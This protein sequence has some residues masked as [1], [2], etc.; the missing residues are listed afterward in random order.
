[1]KMKKIQVMLMILIIT[2]NVLAG[3][4]GAA[5]Q[6]QKEPEVQEQTESEAQ[7]QPQTET[8]DQAEAEPQPQTE[9]ET[10]ADQADQADHAGQTIRTN[11]QLA[12]LSAHGRNLTGLM[13]AEKAETPSELSGEEVEKLDRAMRAYIPPA[14]SLLIN[15]AESFYYYEQMDK[16]EQAIYDALLMCATDPVSKDNIVLASVSVDPVSEEFMEK[17]FVA[18]YGLLYDHPELFWLYNS[19]ESDISVAAPYEQPGNGNYLVYFYFDQPFEQFEEQMNE[20]NRAAEEFLDQIDLSASDAEVARQ[21]HD[22][23]IEEVRYNDAVMQDTSEAG[24]RSLAHT[25][26][27]ALVQDNDGNANCAV[28][29]GYSQAYV[30]LLE[31]AGINA[32][33]IVGV[34]GG[35]ADDTGGHAWTAVELDGEW[36]EVDATWDDMGSLDDAVE[37]IR[38]ADSFSYNYYREALDDTEYRTKLEHYLCNITTPEIEHY[39]PDDYFNYVT[40]DQLYVINLTDESV[41]V[42]ASA[43]TAGYEIYGLLMDYAPVATGT[44]YSIRGYAK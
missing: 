4:G 24:F 29:D 36:Y 43:Q 25:A 7:A 26:Y 42:R 33:M 8:E 44:L 10:Q 37:S 28:C 11:R 9:A 12:P 18:Y 17:Q 19:S 27:G 20:F 1:M 6:P 13:P 23:L 16:D 40:A 39:V 32:A 21:I 38:E 14:D 34:A 31:Q 15:N 41:H 3:C 22:K 2:T 35:N 5:S 30:Y